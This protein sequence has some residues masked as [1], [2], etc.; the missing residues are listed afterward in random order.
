MVKSNSGFRVQKYYQYLLCSFCALSM[1]LPVLYAEESGS[2]ESKEKAAV[3]SDKG[4]L[5]FNGKNLD[6]WKIVDFGTKIDVTVDEGSLILG[7]GNDMNGAVYKGE[8]PK[9]NY[10]ITL[11]AMRVEG[12]D[13][14][15][16][17]TFPVKEDFCS[18]ILGGWGGGLCGLSCLDGMDASE[19]DTADHY[20]FK[21]NEW[22]N[23]R[24][25]VTD[26]R[27]DAWLDKEHLI[28]LD[29]TNRI[30]SLRLETELCKPLGF[31]TWQTKA[32]LKD[33]RVRKLTEKEIKEIKE[34][35]K[36][37]E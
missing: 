32:A 6:D 4:K 16:G 22:Y 2:G 34:N 18:L 23:V 8:I 31:A 30:I 10:E 5:I 14:F 29:Y 36:Q 11:Q 24:L 20:D 7:L 9:S 17:L 25:R 37:P 13:F 35:N 21:N 27:I 19:N 28:D 15:C 3:K 26:N 12:S 33:I 1:V